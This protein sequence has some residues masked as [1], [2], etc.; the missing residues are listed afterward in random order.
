MMAR[1]LLLARAM[2]ARLLTVVAF[3]PLVACGHKLQYSALNPPPRP[4][5]PRA[6]DSVE[7]FM[8]ARPTRPFVDVGLFEIEQMTPG[9][10]GTDAMIAKV[11]A[12]AAN[13]GCD[14]LIIGE[15][16]ERV[17]SVTG[18]HFGT[19][20]SQ[21]PSYGTYQGMSSSSVNVVR[22]HRAVCAVYTDAPATTQV[23]G[24]VRLGQSTPASTT[25]HDPE[26]DT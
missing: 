19:V 12:R 6:P 17:Q 15:P 2:F 20:Q 13:L 7:V 21:G 24:A 22:G 8:S 10:G 5:S 3:V 4:L 9:S 18:Q 14:A 1:R 16:S 11:R 23:S 26:D 25:P